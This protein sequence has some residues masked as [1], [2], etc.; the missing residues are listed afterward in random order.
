MHPDP[1][2]RRFH[3]A[4]L[5]NIPCCLWGGGGTGK[6]ARILAYGA[7]RQLHSE[8]WLLSRCEAIDLKPRI[9]SDGK[10]I[11]ADPPEV[12]RL[13]EKKKGILFLD[14]LNRSTRDVEGAALDIIDHPPEGIIVFAACNPPSRGNAARS[15]QAEAANRFLHLDVTANAAD[16]AKAMLSGWA[17]GSEEDFASPTEEDLQKA[18]AKVGFLVSSFI[19]RRQELLEKQPDNAAQAGRAWPSPRS[20]EFLQKAFAMGKALGLPFEDLEAL[21]G[22]C[23]GAGAATEFLAFAADADLVDP[24]ACLADPKSFSPDPGRVDRTIAA[25]TSIAGAVQSEF[26][27]KRWRAA[28]ACIQ[29]C[30]DCD[31][32]DA[33]IVGSDLLNAIYL[34]HPVEKRNAYTNP[35]K[36]LPVALAVIMDPRSK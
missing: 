19:R 7:T 9:Y 23:V 22:G 12:A 33:G 35:A 34:S 29:R 15:L 2:V 18:S 26:S 36:L 27:D 24:E 1:I 14:E 10:V 11:L 20:W 25:L 21:T 13:K 30:V 16:Y 4:A 6:T 31:Q 17:S 32:K 3:T 5:A 28:W 8:R